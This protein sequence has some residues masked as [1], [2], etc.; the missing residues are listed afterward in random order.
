MVDYTTP[1]NGTIG[2]LNAKPNQCRW[3][4]GLTIKDM[5][6]GSGHFVC[7]CK[8]AYSGVSYCDK[9]M[10]QAYQAG[11]ATDL[12]GLGAKFK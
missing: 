6:K 1:R 2:L 11:T 7:G 8:V 12:T 5:K 4:I 3:P 10:A 9:H